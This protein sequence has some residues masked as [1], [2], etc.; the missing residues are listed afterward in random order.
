MSIQRS[1]TGLPATT[2]LRL[3]PDRPQKSLTDSRGHETLLAAVRFPPRASE[4]KPLG[5][6]LP[7]VLATYGLPHSE[8]SQSFSREAF[9]AVA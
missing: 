7:E 2:I 5:A 1:S 8:I 3:S 9:D 6:L 4:V